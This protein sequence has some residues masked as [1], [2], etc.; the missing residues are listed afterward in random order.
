MNDHA[1][2]LYCK[3]GLTGFFR[4]FIT[5]KK[6]FVCAQEAKRIAID[7]KQVPYHL[8]HY[9]GGYVEPLKLEELY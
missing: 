2:N 6:R 5:N 3:D 8:D 4:G 9:M 7:A 1:E